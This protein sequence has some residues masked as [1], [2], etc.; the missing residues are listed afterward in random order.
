MC[1]TQ[2]KKK[3][4]SPRY[5]QVV[6]SC[7]L[8]IFVLFSYGYV[9]EKNSGKTE[10]R[11]EEMYNLGGSQKTRGL[12]RRNQGSWAEA[13][14]RGEQQIE[15][16]RGLSGWGE[17]LGSAWWAGWME[18]LHSGPGSRELA[19]WRPEHGWTSRLW[20]GNC[21]LTGQADPPGS[22]PAGLQPHSGETR[23]HGP[24]I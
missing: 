12:G 22:L 10:D 23:N 8:T 4:K 18:S 13:G 6:L 19:E 7:F 15:A 21:L 2:E 17:S 1:L 16:D 20:S 24:G 11:G 9:S 3:K 5:F 14:T